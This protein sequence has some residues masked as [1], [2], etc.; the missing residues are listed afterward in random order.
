MVCLC[1]VFVLNKSDPSHVLLLPSSSAVARVA[2]AFLVDVRCRAG[3]GV[4]VLLL[5]FGSSFFLHSSGHHGGGWKMERKWRIQIWRLGSLSS[6]TLDGGRWRLPLL[7]SFAGDGDG[8][9]RPAAS[10]SSVTL[11]AERRPNQ[12]LPAM[13]PTGR[14]YSICLVAMAFGYGSFVA[15]SGHVPRRRRGGS[16]V[17]AEDLIAFLLLRLRSFLQSPR[18]SLYFLFFSGPGCN[19]CCYHE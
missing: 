7:V 11:L 18:T 6:L 16:R 10:S 9:R 12:F 3:S 14:Q 1:L 15:P 5:E 17:G 4:H 8:G 2:G 13:T 19:M